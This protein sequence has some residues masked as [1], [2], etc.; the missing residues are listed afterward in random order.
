VEVNDTLMTAAA[1]A[2]DTTTATLQALLSA[3]GRYRELPQGQ[4]VQQAG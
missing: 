2:E 3:V 4:S 1:L